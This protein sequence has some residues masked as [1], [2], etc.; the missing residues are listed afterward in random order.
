MLPINIEVED[1]KFFIAIGIDL[2]KYSYDD[3]NLFNGKPGRK[4]KI[5]YLLENIKKDFS[6]AK[7]SIDALKNIKKS[8]KDALVKPKAQFG[9]DAT[10]SVFGY[11]EGYIDSQGKPFLLESGIM[12]IIEAEAQWSGQFA[13]GVV[14][15]YWEAYIKAQIEA[16]LNLYLNGAIRSFTPIGTI[17][18]EGTIG[19]GG[20]LG[21]NKLLSVGGG[22]EGTAKPKY[23]MYPGQVN[24]IN[25]AS[26]LPPQAEA[27]GIKPSVKDIIALMQ[28]I[29][30]L[31]DDSFQ[32]VSGN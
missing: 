9:F 16:Q 26:I 30:G 5:K 21:L 25:M 18:G 20:G 2:A 17:E 27:A 28:K 19:G 13:I 31:R 23:E 1:G 29:V 7:K 10:Y 8:Y 11:A 3:K 15:M 14:P 24:V 6:D 4:T 32:L 12:P 22:I